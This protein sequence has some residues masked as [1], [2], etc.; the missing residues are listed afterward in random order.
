MH[1]FRVPP[2][3][4]WYVPPVCSP[5]NGLLY[6]TGNH[7][8][9]AYIPPVKNNDSTKSKAT[10][11]QNVQNIQ[12][13]Q[14]H[15]HFKSIDCDPNWSSSKWFVTMNEQNL[16]WVWDVETSKVCRGHKAHVADGIDR[17]ANADCYIGGAM[18]IS[19]NRQVLSIDHHAFVRYCLISNTYSMF[20][21]NFVMKRG[22]VSILKTSP[23]NQDIIAVGYKNGLIVIVNYAE[24]T[25]LQKLRGHDSEI[26]SLQWTLIKAKPRDKIK[27]NE[28]AFETPEKAS[29]KKADAMPSTSK[30]KFNQKKTESKQ[31]NREPPK[32]IVDAGDMFD[33]HS[34]DYLEEEFGT[35]SSKV[36]GKVDDANEN[37]KV[38]SPNNEHFN[39]VEECQTLREK[40]RAGNDSDSDESS[41]FNRMKNQSAVNMSDIQKFMETKGPNKNDSITLS[42]DSDEAVGIDELSN[43][44]TIGS[45]HNTTEI[46]ELEEVIK[47]LNI[48]DDCNGIVYLVSGAQEQNV[49]IWNIETGSISD[50]IQLKCEKGRPKIPKPNC[51]IAWISP[52]A[53]VVNGPD[54]KISSWKTTDESNDK[55]LKFILNRH[56]FPDTAVINICSNF[57][58]KPVKS[59]VWTFSTHLNIVGHCFVGAETSEIIAKYS[60]L[61]IG[62]FSMR[63]SPHDPN[64]I[65]IAG[66]NKRINIL[67]LSTLKHNN[68][69]IHSLTSKIQGK[70][71]ALSWHPT[72]ENLLS[73][74]TIEGRVGIFNISKTTAAPELMKNFCG[75][76]LYALSYDPIECNLFVTNHESL[77]MFNEKSTKDD[78]HNS[79]RFGVAVSSVS[80]SPNGV[81]VATGFSNGTFK[82]LLNGQD[83][84]TERYS[85]SISK[86]YVS[87]LSW[88]TIDPNKLAVSTNDGKI[89]IY[90]EDADTFKRTGE[91][92][93]HEAGVTFVSWSGQ[94]EHK[95]VSASFDHTVRVWDTQKLECIAWFEYENKMNCAN[96][97]PTDENFVVCSGQSETMHIFEIGKRLVADVGAYNGKKNKKKPFNN[98]VKW[99]TKYQNEASKL[100]SQEKKKLKQLEKKASENVE[101]ITDQLNDV[102]LAPPT[103]STTLKLNHTTILY[104]TNKEINKNPLDQLQSLL[105]KSTSSGD[106]SENAQECLHE[107]LFGNREDV[108][109]LLNDELKNHRFSKTNSIGNLLI[110]QIQYDLKA[111]IIENIEGKSLT[112][113][114]VSLAPSISYEFWKNCSLAYA[115]QCVEQGFTLQ[116]IPHLLAIQQVNEAIEKLCDAHFYREAW[117]IAKMNKESEDKIL[118]T[119][120][121][122]WIQH[123][124]QLGN[125]EGAALISFLSGK[126]ESAFNIL[127]KR[128]FKTAQIEDILGHLSPATP[129]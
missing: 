61:P 35:I 117:C 6:I 38:A 2:S 72:N 9:I 43:R 37:Q 44:S 5:E 51:T 58:Y 95:L 45:S 120:T 93:G 29:Y 109:K 98:E 83:D 114:H 91:L 57:E 87:E 108:M 92:M 94:S 30:Q 42:D 78:N 75:R 104:L 69:E 52:N 129:N 24:T 84:K 64:K 53:F 111:N 126:R 86:K 62:M 122:K 97:L 127:N 20:P 82:I 128:K 18:C 80:V 41:E 47:D 67:D 73:F 103:P 74:S 110:P 88:S 96:F 118:D 101:K 46:V 123:M 21:D 48:N 34:Y 68:I 76:E 28:I 26:V 106:T 115:N 65:A 1:N 10:D 27:T 107:K 8:S 39:F 31:K 81:Y 12:I 90:K 105:Q 40:I 116:A 49:I 11:A 102:Q 119:I 32:P 66:N 77:M 4:T 50:K 99:G 113:Q 36:S 85:E 14:T 33:I 54:G 71:I 55:K 89:F 16:I 13:I 100:Q 25:T 121:T 17:R 60:T 15:N 3:P 7:T 19:K 22:T 79:V 112:E 23:S 56:D 125:L 59:T 63:I 70:V 124:E